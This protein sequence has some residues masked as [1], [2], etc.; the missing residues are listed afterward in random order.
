MELY[1]LF[2]AYLENKVLAESTKR[3]LEGDIKNVY[4]PFFRNVEIEQITTD[5]ICR[6][7]NFKKATCVKNI[8]IYGYYRRLSAFFNYAIQRDLL[9]KNPCKNVNVEHISYVKR[10]LDYSKRYIKELIKL[11]KNTKFYY[12]V[13]FDLHTRITKM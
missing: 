3:S 6:F 8:T 13:L 11:F 7:I 10:D 2:E 4:K 12:M 1:D 9:T 5:D